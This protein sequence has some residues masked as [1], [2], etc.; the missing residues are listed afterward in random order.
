MRLDI[1]RE[2]LIPKGFGGYANDMA[3]L[4]LPVLPDTVA[5]PAPTPQPEGEKTAAAMGEEDS[6]FM[7]EGLYNAL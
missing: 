3:Y 4:C 1:P 7:D 6:K 5:R 2:G